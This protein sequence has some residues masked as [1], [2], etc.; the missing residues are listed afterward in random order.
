MDAPVD[1]SSWMFLRCPF[2]SMDITH[3]RPCGVHV[4]SM[5]CPCSVHLCGVLSMNVHDLFGVHSVSMDAHG[6]MPISCPLVSIGVHE[7]R[8]TSFVLISVHAHPWASIWCS[9]CADL[10]S[11]NVVCYVH[12]HRHHPWTSMYGSILCDHG[13]PWTFTGVHTTSTC[14]HEFVSIGVHRRPWAS[15]HGHVWTSMGIH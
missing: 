12:I 15:I 3:G 6:W 11:I 7:R 10:V 13:C 9:F 4:V 2:V 8:Q 5:W 14:I 1:S